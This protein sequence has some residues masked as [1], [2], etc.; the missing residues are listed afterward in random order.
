LLRF[1]RYYNH[2]RPHASLNRRPPASRLP[3]NNVMRLDI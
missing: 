2:S 1:L 3:V